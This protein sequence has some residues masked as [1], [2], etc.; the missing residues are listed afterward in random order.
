[1]NFHLLCNF[2]SCKTSCIILW[3]TLSLYI[4]PPIVQADQFTSTGTTA[5]YFSP[6]GR[7]TE[8]IIKE[9]N[10]A[11][12]EIL[13]QAYSFTSTP[14]AKALINALKR[15]VK[16]EVVLDKS[17][18]KQKYTSADFVAHAGIPTYIDDKHAIAHNKIMILDRSTLITGSFNFTRAAE[19]KNAENL[20]V[21]MGNK[22]LVDIYIK[23]FEEHNGHSEVYQGK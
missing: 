1:M 4:C 18:R 20:L 7:A 17:Q 22:D 10:S 11:K 13:V 23:N 12:S 5:V 14:I 21:I 8:A 16:I 9:I 3:I 15:G 6:N 19:E 2:I